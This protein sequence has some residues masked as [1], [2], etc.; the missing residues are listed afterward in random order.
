MIETCL[1]VEQRPIVAM[2]K[3]YT[4]GIEEG[5]ANLVEV[6]TETG[7]ESRKPAEQGLKTDEQDSKPAQQDKIPARQA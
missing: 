5:G 1:L 2:M 4:G 7:I 3:Q 6:S